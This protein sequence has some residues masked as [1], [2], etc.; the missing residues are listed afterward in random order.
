MKQLDGEDGYLDLPASKHTYAPLIHGEGQQNAFKPLRQEINKPLKR[1]ILTIPVA[2]DAAFDSRA[3]EHNARCHP[4]T[5]IDL[6][7][8]I[9][10]WANDPHGECIF[11]LNGAAGTGKSTISRTV[12]G[13][14]KE[15]GILG[16]SFFFKRGE[17]DRGDATLFFTTIAAQLVSQ[18]PQMSQSL[19]A[20]IDTEPAIATKALR[21]QFEKLILH[22]L[23]RVYASREPTIAL[24]VD[25]LDECDRD[26]DIKLIIRL[27]SRANAL[28]SVHVRVFITSR[29]ELPIRLGFKDIRGKYQDVALHQIPEPVIKHDISTFLRHEFAKIRE[30]YN[31]QVFDDQQLPLDWPGEHTIQ[32]L[33]RMAIPL[34]IVAATVCR[35]IEDKEWLDPE[36]QLAKVLNYQRSGDPELD[37]LSSTYLPVL[38][39]LIAGKADPTR[40]RLVNEFREI[41][42]PVILLAESLSPSSLSHLLNVPIGSVARTVNGLHAVL[43]VPS[44]ADSPIRPFHLSF[45]DFLVDSK[46][47][48]T[49]PF[50]VDERATH[51]T[52]AT[53][54]AELLSSGDHLK[55][56]IC[57]LKMPGISRADVEPA[58]V[59]ACVPAHVRYACLYWVYHLEQSN[60]RIT[61]HHHTYFFLKTHLLHWLEALSLVDKIS[62]SIAMINK[63][64][65]LL[66]PD[67]SANVSAFLHD[68]TRFV[69]NY[70]S[71][72]DLSP[73]QIYTSAIVFAP[74]RSIIRN[75]FEDS[76]PDWISLLPKVDQDWNACLQVLE[77]HKHAVLALA[78]S[79]DGKTIAS[80]SSDRTVRLWDAAT[81][82]EKQTFEADRRVEGRYH[83]TTAVAF[84][85]DSKT[86]VASED[87]IVRLWDVGTGEEKRTFICHN[88][89]VLAVAFLP[90]CKTIASASDGGIVRLWDITTGKEKQTFGGHDSL[91]WTGR[92]VAF[93]P[94]GKTIACAGVDAIIRLC[95]TT[96]GEE[97]QVFRG[98]AGPY[99]GIA[100]AAFSTDGKTVVSASCHGRMRLWDAA[101]GEEKQMFEGHQWIRAVALSPDG[102]T[103]VSAAAD[104]TVRLWDV[105]TGELKQTLECYDYVNAVV[106]SPDGKTI[107]SASEDGIVRLWDAATSGE[108]RTFET[109]QWVEGHS[110]RYN[111]INALA[112][113]PD[114]KTVVS[115]SEDAKVRL[116]NGNSGKIKQTFEGHYDSVGAVAF[117]PDGK[118]IAS[119]SFDGTVRL[120]DART[121][122]E[123]QMFVGCDG[124]EV[125]SSGAVTGVNAVAFSSDGNTVASVANERTMR[126]WDAAT[127]E[128]KQI[129]QGHS[130]R[131]FAI[132]FSPD[133]NNIAS[134]SDD[135]TVR[136]WDA[137][138]G[139]SKLILKGHDKGV[140][141]VTFS[142]D[143]RTIASSSLDKTLRLWDTDTGAEKQTLST[144]CTIRD[145]SFSADGQYLKTDR[146]LLR[147][148]VQFPATPQ[149]VRHV[150]F[151]LFL[152]EDWV[153]QHGKKVLWLPLD[154]RSSCTAFHSDKFALGR[155][156]SSELNFIQF[157]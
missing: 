20:A 37:K 155:Y 138:T 7:H 109:P 130:D 131:V 112:F 36:G 139:E 134:A 146:G 9:Q 45:R 90:D 93:S 61:D 35:F 101:T 85:P 47:R 80:T 87:A 46:K 108:K 24:V 70:R 128:E 95:D 28:S 11:W 13:R 62:E 124:G 88:T 100:A 121:G 19:R 40:S 104:T 43:D 140:C 125:D 71:I 111:S 56:D 50:W 133:D 51:E 142:S 10:T 115:G 6:L 150:D 59:K 58:V 97:R 41:V 117:S 84:S 74:K 119:A 116:W 132:A 72:I 52:I 4:A 141:G 23:G 8:R 156:G 33:V 14:F 34:F 54:C 105:V 39:Q 73:L 49:N 91:V 42:G 79:P 69:L 118:T 86:V 153:I 44:R 127:G 76:I 89:S 16:A 75:L 25:A 26:D 113:S 78:F 120:W 107:V 15:Q 82:E 22:P 154:Y 66:T 30:D 21:E 53:K 110:G 148:D 27:F 103:V 67:N 81:G 31:N 29:P 32:T 144:D 68:A 65:A 98:H 96:T 145:L 129:F 147:V 38:D 83:I 77:G 18:E 151:L 12:A 99:S 123:K 1:E 157:T 106:I 57:D 114:G 17:R 143:G 63:L 48:G 94:D 55:K 5:R 64:Q 122:V 135:R 126:L 102:K 136:L 2:I 152:S 149:R 60:A 137:T 3:E 92:C